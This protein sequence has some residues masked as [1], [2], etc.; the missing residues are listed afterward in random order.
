LWNEKVDELAAVNQGDTL[1]IIGARIKTQ[2]DGRIEIH[3]E[4]TTQVKREVG[5]AAPNTIVAEATR[6]IAELTEGGPFTVE[7]TI[8]TDP[9]VKEV[10]TQRGEAVLVASLDL[11]DETG[12]IAA[13]LWRNHAESARNWTTGTKI[14]MIGVYVK[15]GFSSPLELTSRTATSIHVVSKPESANAETRI[16]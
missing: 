12:S 15:K 14:K 13:S 11:K 6:R 8:A 3:I 4:N 1:T 10:V 9:V 7:A 2:L 16:Q 5:Q